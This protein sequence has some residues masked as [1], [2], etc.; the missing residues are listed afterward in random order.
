M[1]QATF[2]YKLDHLTTTKTIQIQ[3]SHLSKK[4][5]PSFSNNVN[6]ISCVICFFKESKQNLS[7]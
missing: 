2:Q 4:E 6:I 7:F 5:E 3:A 1:K